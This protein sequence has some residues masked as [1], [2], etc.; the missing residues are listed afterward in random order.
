MMK[1]EELTFYLNKKIKI[2]LKNSFK[3]EG[4]IDKLSDTSLRFLDRFEGVITVPY[5]E[6]ILV[7]E[8]ISDGG[9]K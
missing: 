5:E 4:Q 2:I 7:T 9:Q 3:Y 1:K 6:I 8:K